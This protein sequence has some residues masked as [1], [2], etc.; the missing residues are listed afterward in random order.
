M[1]RGTLLSEKASRVSGDLGLIQGSHSQTSSGSTRISAFG[2]RSFKSTSDH[3]H[4]ERSDDQRWHFT[5]GCSLEFH[6]TNF[7]CRPGV[8][9]RCMDFLLLLSIKYLL[10]LLMIS[11]VLVLLSMIRV[12][13]SF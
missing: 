11:L 8:Y 4:D 5:I 2:I 1:A 7:R 12:E 10:L 3:D 6:R 9:S 13:V